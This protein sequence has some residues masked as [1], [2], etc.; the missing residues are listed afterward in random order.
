MRRPLTRGTRPDLPLLHLLPNALTLG[1]ICAGL[2]A[3]R[4]AAFADFDKAVAL[5]VLA[6]ALDG[7]D[8][9]LARALGS[10]SHLGA[11]LDSLADFLNF[12][13]AP[14]I[15]LYFWTLEPAGAVGWA[16]AMAYALCCVL[17]LARFNVGIKSDTAADKRFFTGV[18]SPFGALLALGPL[19]LAIGL[20][21]LPPLP[22]DVVAGWLVL[23]GLLMVSRLPTFSLKVRIRADHA[24]YALAGIAL[25]VASLAFFPWETLL[26]VDI[27]YLASLALAWRARRMTRKPTED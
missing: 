18:P 20:P 17:R 15:I 27:L 9:R 21:V 7:I 3:I 19:F 5:I 23:V 14:A 4:L 16:A 13:V 2:T 22:A 11:E 6:C 25:A 1:A 10:E 12:G 24:R 26:A 8:G